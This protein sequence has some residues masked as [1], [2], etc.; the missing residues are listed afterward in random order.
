M[1]RIWTE[2]D[3]LLIESKNTSMTKL[4][5]NTLKSLKGYISN[6][7]DAIIIST[8]VPTILTTPTAIQTL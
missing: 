6:I 3:Y 5:P 7:M 4:N 8:G 1:T 2:A